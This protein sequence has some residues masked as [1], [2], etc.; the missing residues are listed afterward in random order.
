MFKT[1]GQGFIDWYRATAGLSREQATT[2]KRTVASQ[3][4]QSAAMAT[5]GQ[6]ENALKEFVRVM[7]AFE[8]MEP[9]AV[10][11]AARDRAH[12]RMLAECERNSQSANEVFWKEA[13][14]QTKLPPIS[15]QFL[16][17]AVE[18][19]REKGHFA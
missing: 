15:R 17:L 6:A 7:D 13:E 3:I 12:A 16:S 2:L 5:G 18:A 19:A 14:F 11:P 9:G 4:R 1:S 8:Q 10:E